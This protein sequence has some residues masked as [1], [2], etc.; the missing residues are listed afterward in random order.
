MLQDIFEVPPFQY[1]LTTSLENKG[2]ND[3]L[4][5]SEVDPESPPS[6]AS[7]ESPREHYHSSSMESSREQGTREE[8]EKE[9]EEEEEGEEEEANYDTAK[10]VFSY[11]ARSSQEMSFEVGHEVEVIDNSHED[12]WFGRHLSSN[13]LGFFPK[14]RVQLVN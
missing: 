6:E 8:K 4:L 5:D 2:Y 14:N 11:R 9:D 3:G 13:K 12:W 10:A 7:G 1:F